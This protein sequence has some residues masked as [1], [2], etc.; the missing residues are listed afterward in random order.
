MAKTVRDAAI[1]L[2]A[3]AGH[4]PKDFDLAPTGRCRTS[5]RR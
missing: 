2:K 4:D 1:M 5:R 3:M